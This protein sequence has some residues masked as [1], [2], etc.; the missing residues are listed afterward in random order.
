MSGKE[1]QKNPEVPTATCELAQNT[2]NKD[3]RIGRADNSNASTW[4]LRND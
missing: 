4:A 2:R 1:M 3:L